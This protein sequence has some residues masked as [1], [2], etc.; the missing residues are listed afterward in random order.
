MGLGNMVISTITFPFIVSVYYQVQSELIVVY[1]LL[2]SSVAY[3]ACLQL[4]PALKKATKVAGL[5]GKD[6][7]KR[8]NKL[9]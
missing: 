1:S 5:F 2:L 8:S 7:N 3:F 4:I 9:M 6:L